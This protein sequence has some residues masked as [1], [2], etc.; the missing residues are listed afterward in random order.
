MMSASAH[1]GDMQYYVGG[2]LNYNKHSYYSD[3]K[4]TI[5]ANNG[6]IKSKVPS[7]GVVAGMK[8]HQNFGAELGYT[9]VKKAKY[10]VTGDS[11]ALKSSNI[12]LDMLGYMP[13]ASNVE[14]IGA[15]GFGRMSLKEKSDVDRNG[16]NEKFSKMGYRIG[17]GAQYKFDNHWATRT[18]VRYQKVGSKNDNK[19]VKGTSSVG[20]GVTYT[21]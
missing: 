19:W 8:F 15:V 7:F 13:V 3:L 21:F 4:D 17:A 1:A 11:G 20:V 14:L 9:F 2:D 5:N 18:M 10:E 12:H 6:S 16:S